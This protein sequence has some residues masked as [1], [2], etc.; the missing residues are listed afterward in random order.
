[1]SDYRVRL[2]LGPNVHKFLKQRAGDAGVTIPSFI[3]HLILREFEQTGPPAN[4]DPKQSEAVKFDPWF[5]N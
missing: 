3:R 4:S 1:M 2:T 5:T